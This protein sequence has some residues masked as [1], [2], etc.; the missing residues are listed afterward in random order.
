LSALE[1]FGKPVYGL[2]CSGKGKFRKGQLGPCQR[3]KS[4]LQ[5][6]S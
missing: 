2:G 4:N 6:A 5:E 1:K 3:I